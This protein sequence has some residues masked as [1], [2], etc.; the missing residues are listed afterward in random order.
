[1]VN[2]ILRKYRSTDARTMVKLNCSPKEYQN[3]YESVDVTPDE[4]KRSYTIL[5]RLGYKIY[6]VIKKEDGKQNKIIGIAI[7]RPDGHLDNN[8]RHVEYYIDKL[9]HGKGYGT[10][11]LKQMIE[12]GESELELNKLIA[13]PYINNIGSRRILEKN[14][15]KR[16][17]IREQHEP[18]NWD[19]ETYDDVVL[20]EYIF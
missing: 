4:F 1:M 10:E 14:G 13:E 3:G 18:Q 11:V 6:T 16:I 9:Y 5:R 20:Y 19:M 2:I 15:F 7:F 12:I 17:G 8:R